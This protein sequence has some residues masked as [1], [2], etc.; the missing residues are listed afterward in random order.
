MDSE[1]SIPGD[2]AQAGSSEDS[3]VQK[4]PA[5]E[6]KDLDGNPVK[7]DELFSGNAV[8]G[9]FLVYHLQSLR[10]RAWGAGCAE[11]RAVAE[12]TAMGMMRQ[13]L[14]RRTY[15]PRKALRIRMCILTPMVRRESSL[16]TFLPYPT[17]YVVDHN[18]NIVGDPIVG[19]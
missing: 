11:Q 6:G 10:R 19:G 5:F 8:T 14:R 18:G 16:Q 17:T 12:K 1:T 2:S 7:S 13:E 15:W 4:F 3:S 9:E